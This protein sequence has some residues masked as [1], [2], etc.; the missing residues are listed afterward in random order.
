MFDLH[1]QVIQLQQNVFI[2]QVS[3]CSFAFQN[4]LVDSEELAVLGIEVVL[5]LVGAH[6][7][8]HPQVLRVRHYLHSY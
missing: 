4:D 7:L 2:Q 3:I 5:F 8:V 1:L 6:F